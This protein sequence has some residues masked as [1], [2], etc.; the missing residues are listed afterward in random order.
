[1]T[2]YFEQEVEEAKTISS[3]S[4]VEAFV[5]LHLG[6]NVRESVMV[7]YLNNSNRLIC[8]EIVNEGT[9]NSAPVFPREIIRSALLCNA[10][11]LIIAH[12]HP[13]GNPNPSRQDKGLTL[14]LEKMASSGSGEAKKKLAKEKTKLK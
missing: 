9:V 4:E 1:M 10:T 6:N 7:L 12:N 13:S 14:E 8:H 11:G 2:R 3:S 5:R